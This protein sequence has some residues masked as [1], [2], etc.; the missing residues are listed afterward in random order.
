MTPTA[1]ATPTLPAA[2]AATPAATVTP[3]R[4]S[5]GA[6][7][8]DR[9]LVGQHL[10]VTFRD[11]RTPGPAIRRLIRR[12]EVAGVILF[13]ENGETIAAA[14][15][16]VNALRR[17]ARKSPIDAPLLVM[18]DQEGGDGRSTGAIR[19]VDAPPRQSA[20]QLGAQPA[21]TIRRAGR[22]TGKALRR[23]GV[24]VNLAPVA[25]VG[26]PGSALV[27]EG[28][29]FGQQPSSVGR[30]TAA[31]VE[32]LR[33]EGVAATLK[34]FPGFGAADLNTDFGTASIARSAGALRD[35]DEAAFRPAV[36]A[37]A[38]LVMLANAVY[39]ALDASRPAG[40]SRRIA[41]RELRDRFGFDGV[42]ITDDL[43]ADALKSFG[44]PGQRAV[45]AVEAGVDLALMGRFAQSGVDAHS[46]LLRALRDGRLSRGSLRRS[47]VRVL[48]LRRALARP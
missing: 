48:A 7:L 34:H 2:P 13:R 9:Q 26:R 28:R 31:F 29:V 44:N 39:P 27:E 42:S 24:N 16:V 25:D 37:G 5:P 18:I 14:R 22:E 38:E 35:V 41:D 23:A 43:E 1:T 19:L 30:G 15:K 45:L 46:A 12:G 10:I 21:S 4:S 33:S 36:R 20:T 32:G 8:S 47:S 6:R 11:T 17:E 3:E 40:L